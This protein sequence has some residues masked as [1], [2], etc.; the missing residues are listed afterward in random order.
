MLLIEYN[1]HM[2][3]LLYFLKYNDFTSLYSGFYD[4][5]RHSRSRW[6]WVLSYPSIHLS[7]SSDTSFFPAFKLLLMHSRIQNW[8]SLQDCRNRFFFVP[9]SS[10]TTWSLTFPTYYRLICHY[11]YWRCSM[12]ALFVDH[13]W[14]SLKIIIIILFL[15]R[16]HLE[17]L[18]EL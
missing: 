13:R 2:T 16:F 5:T 1:F 11:Y 4:N 15:S 10:H 12:S 9:P 17:L 18:K 14:T 7:D 8:Y 6:R 3:I